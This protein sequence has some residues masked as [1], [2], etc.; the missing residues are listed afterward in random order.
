MQR[1]RS[2]SR[3]KIKQFYGFCRLV[4]LHQAVHTVAVI[5][6]T[7]YVYGLWLPLKHHEGLILPT[8][9]ALLGVAQLSL[10]FL[11]YLSSALMLFYGNAT[12][13]SSY[14]VPWLFVNAAESTTNTITSVKSIS[15]TL[16]Y[17]RLSLNKNSISEIIYFPTRID[18]SYQ[19]TAYQ[20]FQNGCFLFIEIIVRLYLIRIVWLGYCLLESEREHRESPEQRPMTVDC[21]SSVVSTPTDNDKSSVQNEDDCEIVLHV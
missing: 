11:V 9:E 2:S 19:S 1:I 18:W 3:A 13:I 5:S 17:L 14:Y 8:R 7:T 6:I 16:H 21:E 15:W 20:H 4:D 12:R 10:V